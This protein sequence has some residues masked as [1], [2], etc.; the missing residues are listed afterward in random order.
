LKFG[1]GHIDRVDSAILLYEDICRGV[2][3]P[4]EGIGLEEAKVRCLKQA[5][6]HLEIELLY[7]QGC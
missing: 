1:S 2:A 4:S 6:K 5:I 7:Y 3:I